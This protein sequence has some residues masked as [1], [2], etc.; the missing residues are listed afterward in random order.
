MIGGEGFDHDLRFSGTGVVFFAA[1]GGETIWGD[2]GVAAFLL[3]E[4][5]GLGGEGE[6]LFDAL[7]GGELFGEGHEFASVAFAFEVFADMEAGE[8]G[9]IFFRVKVKGDTADEIAIEFEDPIFVEVGEDIGFGAFDEF[10][11]IDGLADEH[12]EGAGIFFEDATDLLIL[13]GVDHRADAF[14]AE[15]FAEESFVLA[16]VEEMNASDTVAAGAACVFEF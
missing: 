9:E 15:D 3:E 8:L 1:F 13:V 14:V 5:E 12:H 6:D 11:A 10:L 16:S 4:V 7:F 2:L